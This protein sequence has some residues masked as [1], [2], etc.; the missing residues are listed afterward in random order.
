MNIKHTA[1]IFLIGLV[2]GIGISPLTTTKPQI[3]ISSPVSV[4]MA[5]TKDLISPISEGEVL[6]A[7]TTEPVR[8]NES[9]GDLMKV[10]ES[11]V[12]QEQTIEDKINTGN[13]PINS[14]VVKQEEP[15]PQ[16]SPN[17][18]TEKAV[19]SQA[20]LRQGYAGQAKK[21][22][23]IAVLG[24]SMVDT[25]GPGLPYLEKA[26]KNYYP[27]Y[28]FN[29]LNYGAGGTNIEYGIQRLTSDYEYLGK[30]IP[31][32]VSTHPDIVIVESFAY[33]PWGD[34]QTFLDKHWLAMAKV[35]DVLKA[36]TQAKIMFMATIAPNK[37]N[38]GSGPAGVNWSKDQAWAHADK[39]SKYLENTLRFAAS[40]N[41]PVIDAYHPSIVNGDG[42][43]SYIN[44]GDHIHPS[45]AGCEFIASLM[46]KKLLSLGWLN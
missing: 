12:G 44:P 30:S 22:F 40:Q 11:S 41:I 27:N 9:F 34:Q 19:V 21:Q 33:N 1:L 35:V 18:T 23:T 13:Q 20:P 42:D 37:D 5:Q 8:K 7:M 31:A 17:Q 29:L 43:L 32:L 45:V 6:G 14:E 36:Q 28:Q 10:E 25:M 15:S 4:S 46:A 26:L 2:V 16:P 24:D 39:I 38:F 3:A